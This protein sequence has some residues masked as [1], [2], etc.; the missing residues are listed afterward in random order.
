MYLFVGSVDNMVQAIEE[1][2]NRYIHMGEKGWDY[3]YRGN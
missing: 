2:A 3:G 1:Y